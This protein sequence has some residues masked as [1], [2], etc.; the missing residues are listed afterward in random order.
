MLPLLQPGPLVDL[1]AEWLSCTA[2]GREVRALRTL[3]FPPQRSAGGPAWEVIV[4][5]CGVDP[6]MSREARDPGRNYY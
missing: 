4:L 6:G 3:V 5:L 2:F 1:P